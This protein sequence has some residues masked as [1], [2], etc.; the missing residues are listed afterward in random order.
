MLIKF[1]ESNIFSADDILTPKQALSDEKITRR[2]IKLAKKLRKVAPKSKSF[3]FA[4]CIQMHAAEASLID[5][6]TG[7]PILN[8]NGKPVKGWF[9]KFTNNKGQESVKWISPDSIQPY[10]NHNGDIF[11]EEELLKSYKGW[12]GKA[13]CRDHKSDSVDGIRGIIIDTHY[14]PKFKRV[15]ALF[16]L[17]RENYG[18]LARKVETGYATS[19]SMGTGVGRSVCTECYNVATTERDYCNCVKTRSNYG[20][21][22]L[23]LSPIELS[24][25]VNGADPLAKVRQIV[26]SMNDYA[27]K[28][29]ARINQLVNER[30]VNP[31]ELQSLSD[32]IREMQIKLNGLMN[33]KKS[34]EVDPGEITAL[35]RTMNDP[36]TDEETRDLLKKLLDKIKAKEFDTESD[37]ESIPEEEAPEATRATVGSGSEYTTPEWVGSATEIGMNPANRL[38]NINNEIRLLHSKISEIDKTL[39]KIASKPM[40]YETLRVRAKARREYWLKA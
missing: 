34:A 8:K 13:L 14:D 2:F 27:A 1:G 39:R 38:A 31:T 21:I 37:V 22:N 30:C 15:H 18:D 24:L 40:D 29:Q 36:G 3:L 6:N 25:V 7:K 20:E 12:V 23:D 35:V 33:L 10:K 26:A 32:S 5:Q 4:S 11:S 16:A 9:E 19:V 17:D 28:K